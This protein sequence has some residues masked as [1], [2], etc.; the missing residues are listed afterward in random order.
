MNKTLSGVITHT[1]V[2]KQ[3]TM[4]SIP[5]QRNLL[6]YV[7]IDKLLHRQYIGLSYCVT[8]VTISIDTY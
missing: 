1:Y 8:T 6:Y 2:L 4:T 5:D 7:Y 3:L